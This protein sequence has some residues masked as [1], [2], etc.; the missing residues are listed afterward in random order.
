MASVCASAL[1]V[2]E[3]DRVTRAN[4][5]AAEQML[6]GYAQFGA[7]MIT[8]MAQEWISDALRAA[9]H[10]LDVRDTRGP[11]PHP[12]VLAASVARADSCDPA[13]RR[14][15]F[16]VELPD[17]RITFA[18]SPPPPHLASQLRGAIIAHARSV[19][20]SRQGYGI[21][22]APHGGVGAPVAYTLVRDAAGA[23]AAVYGYTSCLLA[24]P[25][26]VFAHVIS[27]TGVL[28]PTL[29]RQPHNDSLFSVRVTDPSGSELY[30][31]AADFSGPFAAQD[32]MTGFAG[33]IV[34]HLTLSPQLVDTLAAGGLPQAPLPTLLGLL[35]LSITLVACAGLVL[36]HE[37]QFARART[38]FFASISHELRTPL[39]QIRMFAELLRLGRVRSDADRERS[40]RIID[41]EAR[42]LTFLVDNVLLFSRRERDRMHVTLTLLELAGEI[43]AAFDAFAPIAA[44]RQVRLAADLPPHVYANVDANALRQV[45]LNILD[46]AVKYGPAGQTVR[47]T[48]RAVAGR[49]QLTIDDEGPGIAAGERARVWRPFYRVPR[50]PTSTVTGSGLGLAVVHDLV[51]RMNGVVWVDDAPRGGTRI[52]VQLPLAAAPSGAASGGG[53]TPDYSRMALDDERR[54]SVETS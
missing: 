25:R 39:A 54:Q 53:V 2:Y 33:G 44:A 19:F 51:R 43:G 5:T 42:R 7:W 52:V 1:M 31:S 6:R 15:I 12:A 38:I 24:G 41:Q 3:A 18:E 32:A 30:R 16:R 47:A 11:L 14:F 20:D 9:F 35:L 8:S 50:D 46:N 49:A 27:A 23:P 45:V 40:L 28:P 37:E 22:F 17:G 26:S 48:L 10:P 36:R 4:R 13:T 21:V 29:T 34:A